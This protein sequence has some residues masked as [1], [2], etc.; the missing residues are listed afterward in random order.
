MDVWVS[1]RT[2]LT[3]SAAGALAAA[4]PS[5]GSHSKNR[6]QPPA[7]SQP[8]NSSQEDQGSYDLEY[9]GYDPEAGEGGTPEPP[10]TPG[11]RCLRRHLFPPSGCPRSASKP[12]RIVSSWSSVYG[13]A[14]FYA[15]RKSKTP[16]KSRDQQA[17]PDYSYIRFQLANKIPANTCNGGQITKILDWLRSNGGTP[18]L[19]AAPNVPKKRSDTAS[20][21]TDWSAHASRTIPPDPRFLIPGY[22]LTPITGADG[23]KNLRTVIASGQPMAFGTSLY[24]DFKNYNGNPSPYV[25]GGPMWKDPNGKNTGHVMLIVGYDDARKAVRIQN[26]WGVKWG[27]KGFVWMAYDTLEKLAQGMGV[28]IPDSA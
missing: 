2:M 13:L 9:H 8:K 5:C 25:G 10:N 26:S 7:T 24:K 21:R 4:L 16:P 12:N 23:L 1:R 22:K 28:Y 18:T 3:L 19:A 20:C 14:T 17:A 27:K 11:P 6:S 15:A